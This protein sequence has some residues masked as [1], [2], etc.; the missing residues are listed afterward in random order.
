MDMTGARLS[1]VLLLMAYESNVDA[2]AAK[3]E[4]KG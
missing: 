1:T 4:A 2:V 3:T